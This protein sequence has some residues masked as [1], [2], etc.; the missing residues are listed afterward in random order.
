MS[1]LSRHEQAKKRRKIVLNLQP[2]YDDV[3]SATADE[4][5]SAGGVMLTESEEEPTTGLERRFKKRRGAN[6]S[7]CRHYGK[8]PEE[9]EKEAIEQII[10]LQLSPTL[11]RKQS[12]NI[13][14]PTI[15]ND[16]AVKAKKRIAES[17]FTLNWLT[18]KSFASLVDKKSEERVKAPS[19]D[20]LEESPPKNVQTVLDRDF[21]FSSLEIEQPFMGI[22][23]VKMRKANHPS[24]PVHKRND[25]LKYNSA[26]VSRGEE[27]DLTGRS[28]GLMVSCAQMSPKHRKEK[29]KLR[30][31]A[32]KIVLQNERPNKVQEINIDIQEVTPELLTPSP[33]PVSISPLPSM[34]RGSQQFPQPQPPPQVKQ[35]NAR[36]KTI[37]K[38]RKSQHRGDLTEYK[39]RDKSNERM[40]VM[41]AK[42]S[43]AIEHVLQSTDY[44]N[45]FPLSAKY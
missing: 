35:L 7:E 27:Q 11:L 6:Q 8:D 21:K 41:R 24:Y 15:N 1:R 13:K 40:T 5:L 25:Q 42:K 43:K 10:K 23:S 32:E 4:Q 19:E 9:R 17:I 12:E 3:P 45:M 39:K 37:A 38:N 14:F 34:M 36:K 18:A 22:K 26:I 2:S 16:Q 20:D 33:I 44:G 28:S 30:R 31:F 29:D